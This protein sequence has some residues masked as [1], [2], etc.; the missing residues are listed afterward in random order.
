MEEEGDDLL[1]RV[2]VGWQ[3]AECCSG[4]GSWSDVKMRLAWKLPSGWLAV[5]ERDRGNWQPWWW[6]SSDY[7]SSDRGGWQKSPVL[8][9][10]FPVPT[11]SFGLCVNAYDKIPALMREWL[12]CMDTGHWCGFCPWQ[13]ILEPAQCLSCWLFRPLW[14]YFKARFP[15]A[16]L[17][18]GLC[19]LYLV[20]ENTVSFHSKENCP[21]CGMRCIC[22]WWWTFVRMDRGDVLYRD[23]GFS[24]LGRM[25]GF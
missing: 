5:F 21:V 13:L 10:L 16:F 20:W 24:H 12:F 19:V 1:S 14:V 6:F 11:I 17:F 18:A 15:W 23:E 8:W 22:H 3:V 25:K 4:L 7:K 9:F 2:C